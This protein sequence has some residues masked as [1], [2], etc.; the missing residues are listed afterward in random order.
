MATVDHSLAMPRANNIRCPILWTLT[1]SQK[2]GSTRPRKPCCPLSS[3][4][5][6]ATCIKSAS[7]SAA[8]TSKYCNMP[9]APSSRL[10]SQSLNSSSRKMRVSS[11]F[12]FSEPTSGTSC[13]ALFGCRA[14]VVRWGVATGRRP[15]SSSGS[16]T[17]AR[18]PSEG[19]ASSLG[20]FF[21]V[22]GV[23]SRLKRAGRCSASLAATFGASLGKV[24]A[25]PQQ[26]TL[27]RASSELPPCCMTFQSR[28]G[29]S[30]SP[31]TPPWFAQTLSLPSSG[32]NH[33]PRCAT[34]SR[35]SQ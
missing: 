21:G 30:I 19:R 2:M 31:G 15:G 28:R 34:P 6:A 11:R 3:L 33:Q 17:V 25:C 26:R 12:L 7:N 27:S 18:S 5:T 35:S 24:G 20:G 1:M 14:D 29:G 10:R 32:P 8:R 13:S 22:A 9:P 23:G 4:F 16:A